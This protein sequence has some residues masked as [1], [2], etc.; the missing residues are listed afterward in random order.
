M[1]FQ[2]W[3]CYHAVHKQRR[4]SLIVIRFKNKA[5]KVHCFK[6]RQSVLQTLQSFWFWFG[7]RCKHF[8]IILFFLHK[9]TNPTQPRV[10]MLLFSHSTCGDKKSCST[11]R[12]VLY[13]KW[14]H[15]FFELWVKW[16]TKRFIFISYFFATPHSQLLPL[17][18]GFDCANNKIRGR[19]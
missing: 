19:P 6:T 3:P 10:C 2:W 4:K 16:Q 13:H 9:D 11:K 17:T 1:L 15:F 18:E 5:A 12:H 8:P 7:P 14:V